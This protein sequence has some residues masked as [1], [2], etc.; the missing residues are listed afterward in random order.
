MSW[1][2]PLPANGT[3]GHLG[4]QSQLLRAPGWLSGPSRV[5]AAALGS[6]QEGATRAS[7]CKVGPNPTD[8]ASFPFSLKPAHLCFSSEVGAG[9]RE[10]AGAAPFSPS[11]IPSLASLSLPSPPQPTCHHTPCRGWASRAPGQGRCVPGEGGATTVEGGGWRVEQRAG[12]R[13]V[14][15]SGALWLPRNEEQEES[16]PGGAQGSLDPSAV[17]QLQEGTGSLLFPVTQAHWDVAS[18]AMWLLEPHGAQLLQ[19]P[20]SGESGPTNTPLHCA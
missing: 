10:E 20:S 7:G 5:L 19:A 12:W 3:V 4:S 17:P 16:C 13:R 1:R 9:M 14:G 15:R 11:H 8:R 2:T 18:L 6:C